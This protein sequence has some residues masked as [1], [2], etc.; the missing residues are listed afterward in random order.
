MTSGLA[1]EAV[2]ATAPFL[3]I[4]EELSEAGPIDSP[5]TPSS[6]DALARFEFEMGK[7]SDGTK[8]L[9]VEWNPTSGGATDT[10]GH[11]Q[12]D[13]GAWEVSWERKTTSLSLGER[14]SSTM[15]R[16]YFLIPANATIPPVV[17]ITEQQTGR[18]LTARSMPAIFAPGL[19]LDTKKD[20]GKRGVMHTIWAKK[21]LSQLQDEI[22]HEMQDNVEGVALQM[23]M[24]ERDWIVEHFGLVDP[25]A[26]SR[27]A[28]SPVPPIPHSPRSPIGGK[29]GEKLRGL[30][31]A[32]S[33]TDLADSPTM[34][35]HLH[36]HLY[37]LSP[38]TGDIAIPSRSALKTAA[39]AATSTTANPSPAVASLNAIVQSGQAGA[40]GPPSQH[41]DELFAL[42][43]SPRSPEMKKSPF[44]F[45]RS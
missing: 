39:S 41:E 10:S 37:S 24:Q 21:R 35:S 22:R 26:A 43:M 19:G 36:H 13:Q 45:L 34:S 23:A 30:K 4:P 33:P 27:P 40:G 8:I 15:Q 38:D 44:S 9:M 20:A 5:A 42:P 2:S 17:T 7:G 1:T 28:L 25:D 31:L 12:H 6:Q 14:E 18:K 29:L 32:T 11:H 16:V 3:D